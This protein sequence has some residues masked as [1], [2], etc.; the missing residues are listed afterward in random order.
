MIS[1]ILITDSG[2]IVW[3]QKS[4]LINSKSTFNKDSQKVP[5]IQKVEIVKFSL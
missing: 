3:E 2:E 1:M 5:E 4:Y